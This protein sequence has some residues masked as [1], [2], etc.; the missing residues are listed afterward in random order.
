M[1]KSAFTYDYV[2][3]TPDRQIGMNSH[4]QWELSYVIKG[5][6]S[7]TIGNL[8]EPIQ[9]GEIVLIPPGISHVWNFDSSAT[10]DEG[11]ISNISVF[12]DASLL[13]SISR[14]FPELEESVGRII[15]LS[16]ALSF[17]GNARTEIALLLLSSRD[18]RPEARLP[19][20]IRLLSL[21]SEI[22]N[23]RNVGNNN[24][25]TRVERRLERIRT[26]C[27]CN[28]SRDISLKEIAEYA[29]MNK[30]AFCTF[31]KRQTG[32]S[33]SEYMNGLRLQRAVER[34][35]NTDDNI[36]DIAYDV[37]FSSVTYFNRLFR[38]KYGCSPTSMRYG[39]TVCSKT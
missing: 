16:N 38:R 7:R 24:K 21:I 39:K 33:F 5:K 20:M 6:G 9:E 32:K 31:I 37:G 4:P 35:V 27:A 14:V 17:S 25:Q 15:S 19:E 30:S 12:F 23:G 1:N 36:I 2:C 34:L 10:D 18:L 13:D 28:Y 3:V 22:D 29:G 26:F 8:T 11:N